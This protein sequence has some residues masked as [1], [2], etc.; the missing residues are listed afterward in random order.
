MNLIGKILYQKRRFMVGWALGLAAISL[1]MMLF[2]P[3]L[4][5]SEIGQLFTNMS[6]S[7]NKILGGQDS[8]STADKY[9]A[10]QLF[11]L[12]LPLLLIVMNIILFTSL[13][14]GDERRGLLQTE[15]SLPFSR[16]KLLTGRLLAALAIELVAAFGA[17]A[18]IVLGLVLTSQSADMLMLVRH[19]AGCLL[20]ALNFG[21]VVF[22]VGGGLGKRGAATGVATGIAFLSYLI[23][24]LVPI[25]DFLKP[26]EKFSLFHY[27]QN[28]SPASAWHLALFLGIGAVL[29]AVGLL[30]FQRR[31]LH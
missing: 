23:S 13:L 16:S 21:L 22:L 19:M 4:Q 18:G 30:A 14:V 8:F 12:R 1:L 29:V 10:G 28:P 5:K 27:Y 2:F 11:E 24:S 25:A 17:L 15:L 6:P 31:D 26:Y 9:I 20:L 7:L 3:A